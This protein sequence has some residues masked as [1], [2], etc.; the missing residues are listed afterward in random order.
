MAHNAAPSARTGESPN[1]VFFGRELPLPTFTDFSTNTLR[2][3]S[4]EEYVKKLQ[5][6][7]KVVHDAVRKESKAR[8]DKTAEAYNRKAKHHPLNPGELVFYKETPKNCLKTDPRWTGPVQVVKRHPNAHGAPGT[9]YTLRYGDGITFRRN[10]EQL[11]PVK[12]TYDGPISS[13]EC[14]STI[15]PYVP[16]LFVAVSSSDEEHPTP[17]A[18]SPPVAHRTRRRLAKKVITIPQSTST[19]RSQPLVNPPTSN[20]TLTAPIAPTGA[21]SPI[22]HVTTPHPPSRR[23]HVDTS[24]DDTNPANATVLSGFASLVWDHAGD[25]LENAGPTI[26]QIVVAP[27]PGDNTTHSTPHSGTL[28]DPAATPPANSGHTPDLY[29]ETVIRVASPPDIGLQGAAPPTTNPTPLPSAGG[30][31]IVATAEIGASRENSGSLEEFE[32]FLDTAVAELQLFAGVGRNKIDVI[33]RDGYEYRRQKQEEKLKTSQTWV[34]RYSTRFKCKGKM[35][36]IRS[37]QDD[38]PK[39]AEVIPLTEHNHAPYR[40]NTYGC[41]SVTEVITSNPSSDSSQANGS[42]ALSRPVSQPSTTD[43]ASDFDVGYPA[44]RGSS[45]PIA[46][47]DGA[48]APPTSPDPS[49]DLSW[50]LGAISFIE[51]TPP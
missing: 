9:T 39:N 24:D 7:V 28:I 19:S 32:Q 40:V 1:L 4:T 41:A 16:P 5:A 30:D 25:A 13:N 8:S 20:P 43:S 36:I 37:D 3:K 50:D 31:I 44:G 35:R 17:P 12:A 46:A 27:P 21:I 23:I 11:K 2:D 14:P 10:Y 34:C 29:Q 51:T 18:P 15:A 49:A 42:S 47:T 38:F 33:L 6:R 26:P 45:S 22:Q 48:T